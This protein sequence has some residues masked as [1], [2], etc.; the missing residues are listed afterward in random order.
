[1]GVLAGAVLA[2][3]HSSPLSLNAALVW[4]L[5]FYMLL[6]SSSVYGSVHKQG[7]PSDKEIGG[8]GVQV[9]QISSFFT[10]GISPTSNQMPHPH[11]FKVGPVVDQ[12]TEQ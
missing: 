4:G 2:I 1:V 5:F 8:R 11:T 7:N 9:C 6:A 12:R 10:Q 3:G